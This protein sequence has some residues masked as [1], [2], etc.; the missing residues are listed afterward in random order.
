MESA[1]ME[2]IEFQVKLNNDLKAA[3]KTLDFNEA[4]Y[5]VDGY[6]QIQKSRVMMGGQIR[7]AKEAG[8]PNILL[9]WLFNNMKATEGSIKSGLDTFTDEHESSRWMKSIKGIGP[10][11]SAGLIAHIDITKAATAGHIWSFAGLNP[12]Q[13]WKKGEKRPW[14]A[15]LKTLC[16]K[17]GESFVKTSG[18][19]MGYYGGL[20]V[21]RKLYEMEMNDS[22]K[23]EEQ[24]KIKL[25]KYNIKKKDV[26]AIYESG[27][28]PDGHIHA[29]AKRWTVKLFLSHAHWVMYE[30]HYQKSPP[31]PYAIEHLGHADVIPPPNWPRKKGINI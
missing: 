3:A 27:K 13:E 14:N 24:A 30:L 25:E 23:L 8:E 2:D 1:V 16:W 20:F 31:I 9:T 22:G 29:R 12:K 18:K 7:A 6:Y 19:R 17:I 21:E 10:V 28:L 26:R 4:R 5:L 15:D 11:I